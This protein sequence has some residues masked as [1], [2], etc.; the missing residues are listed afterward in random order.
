MFKKNFYWGCATA[1]YQIE[2]AVKEDGRGASVWDVFSHTFGKTFNAHTGDVACDHYH[3]FHEDVDIMG[4]IGVNAYR[5]SVSW[6]RVIPNGVGSVN[7]KGLDFYD[8]LINELLERNITP[9]MTLFHWDYPYELYKKGGWMNPDSPK[10]MGEYADLL[11]RRFGDRVKHFI[12]INEPQC[13]IGAGHKNGDH[14]PGLRLSDDDIAHHVRNTLLAH[15]YAAAALRAAA[16]RDVR[17][18]LAPCGVV[19][20]PKTSMDIEAAREH[21]FRDGIFGNTLWCDPIFLGDFHGRLHEILP[22]PTEE[23]IALI[24]APTDFFGM[25]TYSGTLVETDENGKPRETFFPSGNART[26]MDWQITPECLYW[27]PR[28]F[29]ERYGKP[30]IITENGMSN[31]DTISED[32]LCHDSQ[33]IDYLRRHLRALARAASDGVPIEGYFQW[34][35]LDNFEWAQGYNQRFGMV[36]VDYDTQKRTLKDSAYYYRDVILSE[37]EEL[38]KQEVDS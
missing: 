30:V 24:S 8:A 11:A 12:T 26:A 14:A 25:N 15:G 20:M 38:R 22:P 34:S 13:F 3:R 29:Y 10:W 18:G 7:E 17:I 2:G 33:R 9:F 37:G 36:Y 27:G 28:F 35:L 32:G 23:E 16:S 4:K 1:A 6:S 5:F 21:M 19:S 31:C